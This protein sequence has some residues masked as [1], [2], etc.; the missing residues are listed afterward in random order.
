MHFKTMCQEALLAHENA[1]GCQKTQ[2]I[3]KRSVCFWHL[4]T[5][6]HC[7]NT[8]RLLGHMFRI[9]MAIG[10]HRCSFPKTWLGNLNIFQ[11]DVWIS[12]SNINYQPDQMGNTP[13][14]TLKQCAR[15]PLGLIRAVRGV[16]KH[17]QSWNVCLFIN[18]GF[19]RFSSVFQCFNTARL[20]G[21]MF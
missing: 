5:V 3:M 10:S 6:F 21:H 9:D 18:I 7:F 20:L 13:S 16:G 1:Q 12:C 2:A 4:S 8:A 11:L 19:F 17:K 14:C 15:R